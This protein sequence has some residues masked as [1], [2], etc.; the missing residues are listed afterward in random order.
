MR[1]YGVT[2]PWDRVEAIPNVL[3]LACGS[4]QQADSHFRVRIGIVV[5][6]LLRPDYDIR[7][8]YSAECADNVRFVIWLQGAFPPR[9]LFAKWRRPKPNWVSRYLGARGGGGT[10]PDLRCCCRCNQLP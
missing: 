3:R 9:R 4:L 2:W 5:I 6:D 7:F 8:L 10:D 1:C